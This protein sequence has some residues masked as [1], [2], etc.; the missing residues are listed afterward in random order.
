WQDWETISAEIAFP[1]PFILHSGFYLRAGFDPSQIFD[2]AL[3]VI[4]LDLYQDA[5]YTWCGDYKY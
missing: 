1:E 2:L 3:S 4:G 5:A